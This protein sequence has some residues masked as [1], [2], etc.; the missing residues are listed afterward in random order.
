MQLR[1]QKCAISDL[2]RLIEISRKTFVAAFEKDNNPEDFKT[3]VDK[4]FDREN[5]KQQLHNPNSSFYFTFKDTVL[6]GYFKL[7]ENAAQTD[8]KSKEYLELERVYVLQEFQGNGI[9]ARI[10][11][12]IIMLA[13]QKTR[14]F[15]WLGVWEKNGDAIRFYQKHGF[16]KFGTHPYYIGN[17]KQTDW[18]LRYDLSNFRQS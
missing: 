5:I 12:E 18:L 11:K 7:N 3:Y 16:K 6:V 10:L 9:G 17:D 14:R 15:I 13:S 8:I 4:A 1:F 2:D